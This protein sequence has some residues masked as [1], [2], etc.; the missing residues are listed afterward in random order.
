MVYIIRFNCKKII[1]YIAITC[2][3]SVLLTFTATASLGLFSSTI[4]PNQLTDGVYNIVN[5][6]TGEY[7]DVFDTIYDEQ[8]TVYLS[9]KTGMSGQD[10]LIKRQ[11]DGSYIIYS[12]G[13]DKDYSLYY[14]S[15][16]MEGELIAKNEN[17]TN[18][19]KFNIVPVQNEN[20]DKLYYNIKPAFMS[21]DKLTLDISSIK[22]KYN[23][24]LAGLALENGSEK[25]QWQL[26]KVSSESLS[27]SSGY[28]NVR[29]GEIQDIYTKL[30]PKHLIGNM[31]WKSSNTDVATVDSQGYVYGV[32]EGTATI[33][34]TCGKQ[35][36]STVV[37]VTNLPAY[38]W[39]SQHNMYTGGWN[40][41]SLQ[42]LYLTTFSG[43]RK[44]FFI[45]GYRTG[46]DWM[47]QGCKLCSESMILHNM[48]AV[49]TD[50]YDMRYDETN[51]LEADPFT[52]MLANMG[53]SGHNLGSIRVP[54]NPVNVGHSNIDPR[55]TVNGNSITSREYYGNSL[56][57]IKELLDQHPEGVLVGMRNS[58]A[59]RTH[60]VVFTECLNPN[61]PYGNYEFRICDS[62]ASDPA[63]GDNVPFKE[64]ISYLSSGYSYRS[65]FMYSVYNIVE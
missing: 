34:V 22:G 33:T 36:A 10:F 38:T 6:Q 14:Q 21:D 1:L 60:Y 24:T 51:N 35:T 17:V 4:D 9:K 11:D 42:N 49:L 19:S 18:Q 59:N 7:L 20:S 46:A 23:F 3:L 57:H 29:Q 8:G 62:A 41:A 26:V 47:D 28:I 44:L 48:G 50:G 54:R 61:D 5:K 53:I 37:K 13:E 43:E 56:K 27:I 65:I 39:Y 30:T 25:Q 16:I 55:F 32:S 2:I 12:L 40:A 45:N 64:S 15:D 31:E 63:L 52:V 58:Y